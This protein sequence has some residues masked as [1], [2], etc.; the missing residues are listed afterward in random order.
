MLAGASPAS[1]RFAKGDMNNTEL[2]RYL[3]S[4]AKVCRKSVRPGESVSPGGGGK[5]RDGRY[6]YS[7][8]PTSTKGAHTLGCAKRPPLAMSAVSARRRASARPILGLAFMAFTAPV[9][10]ATD[11]SESTYQCETSSARA[12]A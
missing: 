12:P 3:Q 10:M 9:V 4:K 6:Y 1:I 5:I 8:L 2:A 7:P 11:A